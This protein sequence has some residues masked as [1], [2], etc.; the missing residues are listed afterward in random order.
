MVTLTRR[1]CTRLVGLANDGKGR[2][3]GPESG[4]GHQIYVSST[5]LT[6]DKTNEPN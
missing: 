6:I 1:G 3:G 4:T 5:H 2:G